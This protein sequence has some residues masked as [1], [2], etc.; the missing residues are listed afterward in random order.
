MQN[1]AQ[2]LVSQSQTEVDRMLAQ[3]NQEV[4]NWVSEASA[5]GSKQGSVQAEQLRVKLGQLRDLMQKEMDGDIL[6][7]TFESAKELIE[8]ELSSS[9]M[10]LV[11][12]VQT[13]LKAIPEITQAN[14]RVNPLDAPILR[15]HKQAIIDVM[16]RAKEIDIR[17]DKQVE[18][19]GVLIHTDSGVIDAQLSTQFGEIAR[20]FGV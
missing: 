11:Q 18:R 3:A 20:V 15:E 12:I 14:L 8:A 16:E 9:P 6:L 13:A 17:E 10:A 1:K 2:T 4:A 19:G 7:A 5:E